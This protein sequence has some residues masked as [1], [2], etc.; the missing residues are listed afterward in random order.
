MYISYTCIIIQGK[1]DFPDTEVISQ[2]KMISGRRAEQGV[3]YS[4]NHLPHL[5]TPPPF[6]PPLESQEKK[7][8][9]MYNP[10]I[11]IT[12]LSLLYLRS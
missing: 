7:K 1:H 8:T 10:G 9:G 6:Q 3:K 5:T 4:L 2:A 12:F 11:S